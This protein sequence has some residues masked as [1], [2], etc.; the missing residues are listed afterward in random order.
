MNIHCTAVYVIRLGFSTFMYNSSTGEFIYGNCSYFKYKF[1]LVTFTA[2]QTILNTIL[3][4]TKTLIA[5]TVI[6]EQLPKLK[7]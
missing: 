5:R 3:L 4:K 6:I 1:S 2:L 7:K